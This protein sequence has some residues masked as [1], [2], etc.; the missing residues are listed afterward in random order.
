LL[1]FTNAGSFGGGQASW[2]DF[3]NDGWSDLMAGGTLYRNNEGSLTPFY[4]LG[5]KV[6]GATSTV[7][8]STTIT[9]TAITPPGKT[10]AAP[11]LPTSRQCF[12][13]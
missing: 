4:G 13:I 8:V 10:T 11:V 3:D 1:S 7:T 2:T 12:P 6:F 5:V 9:A